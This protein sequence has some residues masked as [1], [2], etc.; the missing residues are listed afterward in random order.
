LPDDTRYSAS[1]NSPKKIKSLEEEVTI[2]DSEQSLQTISPILSSEGT[3]T[4][5]INQ[6]AQLMFDQN[7]LSP[8]WVTGLEGGAVICKDVTIRLSTSLPILEECLNVTCFQCEN[9]KSI[10]PIDSAQAD[11]GD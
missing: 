9:G 10:S 5:C 1:A 6:K 11:H 2:D 3:D 7:Q 4:L 8:D